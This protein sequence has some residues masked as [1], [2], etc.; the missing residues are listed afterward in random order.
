MRSYMEVISEF[1][2][3]FAHVHAMKSNSI[4]Y[5]DLVF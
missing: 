3:F 5:Y 4:N 1:H 2:I